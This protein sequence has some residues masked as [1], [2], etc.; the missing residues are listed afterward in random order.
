MGADSES[1]GSLGKA[2]LHQA[3]A[4][5]AEQQSCTAHLLVVRVGGAEVK[6][7]SEARGRLALCEWRGGG[8]RGEG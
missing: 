4:G 2:L 1:D 3:C 7:G 8:V 6:E 5:S